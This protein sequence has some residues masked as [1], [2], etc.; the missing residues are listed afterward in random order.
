MVNLIHLIYNYQ[1][2]YKD[3]SYEIEMMISVTDIVTDYTEV[4]F[5]SYL[6]IADMLH[7]RIKSDDYVNDNGLMIVSHYYHIVN[8]TTGN[9]EIKV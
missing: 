6:Q 2:I 1:R 7:S 4:Q 8:R 5:M 9:I 3:G